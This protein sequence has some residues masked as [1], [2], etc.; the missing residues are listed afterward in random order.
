MNMFIIFHVFI[1]IYIYTQSEGLCS[2]NHLYNCLKMGFIYVAYYKI[3]HFIILKIMLKQKQLTLLIKKHFNKKV[4][5]K[6]IFQ[7]FFFSY[8]TLNL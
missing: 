7:H 2:K 4:I 6:L 8:Y 1:N 5:K 3:M